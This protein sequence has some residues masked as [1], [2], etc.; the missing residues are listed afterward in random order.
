[1]RVL[2]L[3]GYCSRHRRWRVARVH[4]YGFAIVGR[5]AV[6]AW[7]V[8][9]SEHVET[10]SADTIPTGRVSEIEVKKCKFTTRTYCQIIVRM[11]F[12]SCVRFHQ[13]IDKVCSILHCPHSTSAVKSIHISDQYSPLT[14]RRGS[15]DPACRSS[16]VFS[17]GKCS[18]TAPGVTWAKMSSSPERPLHACNS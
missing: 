7:P 1:M 8:S 12:P 3:Y 10:R 16:I 4:P 9:T 15:R 5:D 11:S 6:A 18:Q 14:G 2:A 17:A 13:D